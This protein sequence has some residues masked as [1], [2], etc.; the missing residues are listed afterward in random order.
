ML[1]TSNKIPIHSTI[2]TLGVMLLAHTI[3]M[4][5]GNCHKNRVAYKITTILDIS[6]FFKLN[7]NIIHNTCWQFETTS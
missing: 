6:G 3:S 1:G 7:V 2:L 5:P 4:S